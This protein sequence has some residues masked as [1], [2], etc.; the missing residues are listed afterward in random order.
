MVDHL[1]IGMTMLDMVHDV[2]ELGG[3]TVIL[4]KWIIDISRHRQPA[5]PQAAL[6]TLTIPNGALGAWDFVAEQRRLQITAGTTD[7]IQHLQSHT[8]LLSP[9]QAPSTRRIPDSDLTDHLAG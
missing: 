3:P 9:P 5:G 1:G 8:A 2:P 7:T 4:A 6:A